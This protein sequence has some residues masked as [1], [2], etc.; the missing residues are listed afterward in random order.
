M[1]LTRA[2]LSHTLHRRVALI[3]NLVGS[4]RA[5][6]RTAL[7]ETLRAA[8]LLTNV[9]WAA[10]DP[11]T[12]TVGDELQGTYDNLMAALDATLLV[13]V[14]MPPPFD[15]RFGI[16]IGAVT[17]V[18]DEPGPAFRRQDGQAWWLARDAIDHVAG[19]V[20]RRHVPSTLRTW[21]AAAAPGDPPDAGVGDVESPLDQRIAAINAF[22]TTR[23][24][25]VSTMDGRDRRIL[26]RLLTGWP[27]REIAEA[28]GVS[29][30]AVS[31]RVQ[32]SGAAAIM[33]AR[34]SLMQWY[35][36]PER[37]G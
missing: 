23:D 21:V 29:P 9:T 12:P 4:R 13:R 19:G 36:T 26:Q 33:Y 3:G 6:D 37:T 1:C 17:W 8:L 15:V 25:L 22:L 11:L 35:L 32:R 34:E 14:S 5:L 7:Q 16:G 18:D 31:Q 27:V 30:S 28:E 2:V 24:H 20:R 10:L